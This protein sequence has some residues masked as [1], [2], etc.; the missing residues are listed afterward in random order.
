MLAIACGMIIANVYYA[1]P[2]TG[3]IGA[4]LELPHASTGLLV[5]LPLAGYGI[6]LLTIVPLGDLFENRRLA[7]TLIGAEL[8]FT[9]ALS[10]T[11][12]APAYLFIAFLIGLVAS[13]VQLLVPYVTYLVSEE[14]RGRA[15]GRVVSG[16]MLGIM[17]A[18][19]CR[20]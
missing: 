1:Q 15:V 14:A 11:S 12:W 7:L 5:T 4:T 18:V 20:A 17:L 16:V 19:R 13:A 2:L 9:L 3:L 10:L 6:G 8:V